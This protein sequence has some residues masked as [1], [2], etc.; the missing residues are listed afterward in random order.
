MYFRSVNNC[1]QFKIYAERSESTKD[2]RTDIKKIKE[3]LKVTAIGQ[4][5]LT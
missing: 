4:G 2:N 5:C 1:E 3:H